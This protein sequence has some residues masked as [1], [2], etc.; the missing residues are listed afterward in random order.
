VL[1]P[2]PGSALN[3]HMDVSHNCVPLSAVQF[4]QGMVDAAG[5]WL[6]ERRSRVDPFTDDPAAAC[7]QP[8]PALTGAAAHA[9][10]HDAGTAASVRTRAGSTACI[11]ALLGNADALVTPR[12]LVAVPT[13]PDLLSLA[14]ID[15][16]DDTGNTTA[17]VFSEPLSGAAAAGAAPVAAATSRAARFQVSGRRA[18]HRRASSMDWTP[19]PDTITNSSTASS[20]SKLQVIGRRRSA[21]VR[22]PKAAPTAAAGAQDV[23]HVALPP[24]STA[25]HDT[26]VEVPQQGQ[27]QQQQA[28]LGLQQQ[29]QQQQGLL[30]LLR[31]LVGLPAAAQGAVGNIGSVAGQLRGRAADAVR[32]L[33]RH[34]QSAEAAAAAAAAAGAAGS[35]AGADARSVAASGQDAIKGAGGSSRDQSGPTAGTQTLKLGRPA[36]AAA[37][38]RSQGNLAHSKS[39]TLLT[40]RGGRNVMHRRQGVHLVFRAVIKAAAVA[41]AV[42]IGAGVAGV[43]PASALSSRRDVAGDDYDSGERSRGKRSAVGGTRA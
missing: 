32:G 2:T 36:A 39:S 4:V 10:A 31:G 7:R 11:D 42:A 34:F 22:H 28:Q 15:S 40:A 24:I 3:R 13:A 41:A 26:P 6:E 37:G 29:Q 8:A 43:G 12:R 25:R 14:G 16:D 17:D 35:A 19:K 9:A 27:L 23:L 20:G 21:E 30:H 5:G 18:N 1:L 38:A 33:G